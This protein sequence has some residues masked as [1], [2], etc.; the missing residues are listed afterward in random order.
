MIFI[1]NLLL[2]FQSALSLVASFKIRIV[3][4][5]KL[6]MSCP[7]EYVRMLHGRLKII[8][9]VEKNQIENEIRIAECLRRRLVTVRC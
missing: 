9:E 7:M 3:I 6:G 2:G 1:K 8:E 5:L 4:T